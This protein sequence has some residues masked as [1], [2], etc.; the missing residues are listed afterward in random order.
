MGDKINI[1][2]ELKMKY[3]K[4]KI[5]NIIAKMKTKP[6]NPRALIL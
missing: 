6:K 2:T 5:L 3:I 4:I 1:K